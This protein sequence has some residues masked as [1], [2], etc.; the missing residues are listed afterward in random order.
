M[1]RFLLLFVGLVCILQ[2]L[3]A[4]VRETFDSNSLEWTE[5]TYKSALGSAMITEGKMIVTSK[6]E[7][8][9]LG[10]ALSA[11][12]GV[13][14]KV[15]NS[16]FFETHCYAPIDVMKPF[17][18]N[19]KVN[20]KSLESDRSVGVVFNYKD[21]GNFYT[22]TF[23]DDFVQFLRYKDGEVA[24]SIMQ[25]VKWPKK[26]NTSMEWTLISDGST[27]EFK[28]DDISIL[29]I[30]HMPLEYSGFGYYVFGAQELEVDE[31]VFMQ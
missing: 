19:S 13:A 6:G 9:G 20:V 10:I 21:G 24:G 7:L 16:T 4:Q 1:K 8:K 31:V 30:R 29:K 22:F 2:N 23:N 27:I 5:C 18:I 26:R 12:S 17:T 15:R 3:N 28:V 11:V 14:T 25:G